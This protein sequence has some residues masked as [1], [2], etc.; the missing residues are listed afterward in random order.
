[1]AKYACSAFFTGTRIMHVRV[2]IGVGQRRR[3]RRVVDPLARTIFKNVDVL[4]IRTE[5]HVLYTV[6][7]PHYPPRVLFSGSKNNNCPRIRPSHHAGFR[8]YTMTTR[9][10]VP[11][12]INTRARCPKGTVFIY[13]FFDNIRVLIIT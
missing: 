7:M 12:H 3:R 5:N 9:P 10:Y 2:F 4:Q 6:P 1:M 8:G 11:R 13:F